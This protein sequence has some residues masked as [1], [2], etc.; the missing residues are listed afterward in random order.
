MRWRRR[1]HAREVSCGDMAC[2]LCHHPPHQTA[3]RLIGLPH[4]LSHLATQKPMRRTRATQS[5]TRKGMAHE[6]RRRRWLELQQPQ[7]EGASEARARVI[8]CHPE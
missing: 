2:N 4:I 7:Q 3:G 1:R 5:P 6:G 8:L